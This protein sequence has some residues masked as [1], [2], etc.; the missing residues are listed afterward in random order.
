MC[1]F[2]RVSLA[3][4]PGG[5]GDGTRGKSRGTRGAPRIPLKVALYIVVVIAENDH[6]P[7]L[8][9]SAVGY[10]DFGGVYYFRLHR[11]HGGEH[12]ERARRTSRR[13]HASSRTRPSTPRG[14]PR[15]RLFL[16]SFLARQK[17]T[18][19]LR[20]A[21]RAADTWNG[22]G[23]VEGDKI[24][25]TNSAARAPARVCCTRALVCDGIFLYYLFGFF[26]APR[27]KKNERARR[28]ESCPRLGPPNRY[29]TKTILFFFETRDGR[30][31][32]YDDN[33]QTSR[34][35]THAHVPAAD[36]RLFRLAV[37]EVR[38]CVTGV[39]ADTGPV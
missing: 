22:H 21:I 31:R 26:L 35:H 4:G 2:E 30:I 13:E 7:V 17:R 5:A 11:L 15:S 23:V 29:V 14:R 6:P 24:N 8:P 18:T 10:S 3:V 39:S 36:A 25:K 9:P 27:M 16:F 38:F 34:V 19:I 32:V 1:V 28:P 37:I 33:V 12:V 20:R